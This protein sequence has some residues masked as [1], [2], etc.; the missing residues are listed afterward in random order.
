M[1]EFS[2][3]GDVVVVRKKRGM[4]WHDVEIKNMAHL[5]VSSKS[6]FHFAFMSSSNRAMFSTYRSSSAARSRNMDPV[7]S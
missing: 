1:G 4:G 7:A 3:V 2:C 6:R 5:P